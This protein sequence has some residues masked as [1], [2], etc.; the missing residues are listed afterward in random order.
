MKRDFF[1]KKRILATIIIAFAFSIVFS[2]FSDALK[3]EASGTITGSVYVDYNMNGARNTN[4]TAPNYAVDEGVG[5]ATVSLYDS[6]GTLSGTATTCTALNSPT[7][8]CTGNNNGAYSLT[9]TGTGPYR[10]E[11]TNLPAGSNPS[12]IGTNNSTTVR[13]IAD[14]NSS[15]VDL[16][17]VAPAEYCQNVPML[18][19]NSYGVGDVDFDT[20]VRYPYNYSDE[21][22]GRLNSVDSTSWTTAPS[23]T[24]ALNPTSVAGADSI[25]ST[26]GLAWNKY[27]DKLYSAAYLKRGAKFGGL[28]SES[29]GAIYVTSSP[30]AVS[31]STALYVDLNAVFGAGTTGA[32]T[33]PTATTTDW[34]AD[35]A[36]IP[37]IGK[38]GLGGMKISQDGATLYAV[39][40]ADRRLYVIPTSGTLNSTTITRFSVPTS[41]LAVTGGTCATADVRPFAVGRDRSGQIY[42]GAVCSAESETADAKLHAFIWRFSGSAFTLVAN[43]ALSFSRTAGT[44][45]AATWQRWLATVPSSTLN[46]AAPMITDIDFDGDDMILGLRDRYGDQIVLPDYYRGYGDVMRVCA[47]GSNFTFENNGSC[48][49]VTAGGSAL[50]KGPGGGEY[51]SDLNGDSREEGAL[52]GLVQ[53]PGFNHVISTFYDPVSYNSAGTRVNN[54]YTAGIQRYS[55]TTGAMVGAYDVYLEADTGNFGKADGNG[56][57]EV[58]CDKAPIQIGN[59]VWRDTDGDGV[60][61]ANE[62]GIQNV[63]VR[64]YQGST[65]I[66]SAVTD[67]SGN[68]YFSSAAGT[69]TTSAI[70]GLNIQRTTAY[71]IRLDNAAN[72]T[73][74]GAL[75]GLLLT[76]KNQTSQAGFDDGTDS[77]AALIVNPAGSAAGTF[78]VV[79]FTSGSI[80]E[81]NHTFDFGFASSTVYS[82]GNRVWFDTNNDGMINA[83]EVGI[84]NVSVSVFADANADGTPDTPATAVASMNT[85]ANGYYRFD[86]LT[87]GNYV[88]R[89]N[90]TNFTNGASLAGYQNTSGASSADTDSTSVAGQNGENGINPTGAANLIQSNGILSGTINLG[91]PG[92]PTAESDVQA[93]GQGAIDS[94]AN[95]TVDFGFF[96]ACVSGTVWNDNGAGANNNNGILNSG[97]SPISFVKV[98]LYDASNNEVLVGLDGILGTSDDSTVGTWTNSSGNY[99]LCGLAPTQYRVVVTPNGGTSSTPTSNTPDNNIDS[100]DN[101]FPGTAPFVGRITAGLVTVTPGSTGALGNTVVTNANALTSNPTIDFGFVLPPTAIRLDNLAAYTDGNSVSLKWS[102]GGESHNLGFNLYRETNGKRELLNAAPIA[103]SA[104]RS[105][106]ELQASA[107]SYGW[108]DNDA[109]LG[110]VYYLEDI[111]IDGTSTMHGPIS[112]TFK[113]FVNKFERNSVLLNDLN[114]TEKPSAEKESVGERNEEV[115]SFN[116]AQ[117]WQ[118]AAQNAVKIHVNHDGWYQVSA[119]Q[120]QS[121]GFDTNSNRDNWQLFVNAAQVPLKVNLDG[122]IEFFGRGA[123]TLEAGKQVYYLINGS[124]AGLRVSELKAGNVGENPARSFPVT[125][126]RKDRSM[127]VSSLLNGDDSNWFGAIVSTNAQTTQT[128]SVGKFDAEGQAHVSVK[129][130]GL[131]TGAHSVNVRFNE[132]DLGA[133]SL[134]NQE[135]RQ[136]E[137]DVPASSLVEGA[138]SVKLQSIGAGNDISLVDKVSLSYSRKYEPISDKLLFTVAAGQTAK[139]AGF[140][141]GKFV[142][143]QVQDGQVARQIAF[144]TDQ[145]DG[146]YGFGLGAANYDREFIALPNSQPEQAAAVERNFP[147]NWNSAN[148]RADFVII[149]PAILQTQAQ[150]LADIRQNQGL[151]TKVVLAEDVADEFAA[152]GVLTSDAVRQFLQT[153]V[154]TWRVKPKY[155][156]L[157]G[158]SSY[159]SRGYLGQTNRNLIPTR[160]VDTQFMETS[161]DAWLADF[162]D[163]G[164]ENIALGRLPAANEAE[165]NLLIAKLIRY[166]NQSTRAEKSSMMVSDRGF[167]SFTELVQ[168]NLPNDV[169]KVRIDRAAMSDA[170]MRTAILSGLSDNPMVVTYTGHGTT[171]VWSSNSIFNYADAGN[172]NNSQLS[173]YMLMTCLNGFTHNSTGDSLAESALKAENGGAAVVWASSGMT[174]P[175]AQTDMS[176]EATRLIFNQNGNPMRIGDIARLAKQATTDTDVRRTWQIIGDPTIFVK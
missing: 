75:T 52:G 50:N 89:V 67:A 36:T 96:R 143:Y 134:S 146:E 95:M 145:I 69:N 92:E 119:A 61:D 112:P 35:N 70:Y 157:F 138:N 7:A 76:T 150:Q 117:Q 15:N 28:S 175:D 100:D 37:E 43:T 154:T 8:F 82:L 3:T 74:A 17:V 26:F 22:D 59:R 169:R 158:D 80:G 124:S 11:F 21:L 118:I 167:E 55:N 91:A 2:Q 13:F 30:T 62:N 56:D 48:G 162:N 27:A 53:V 122:A 81:N 57:S 99:S 19:T 156:L 168:A 109:K 46:R 140:S 113:V 34:T 77:D 5:G 45:E 176:K 66:S 130:Q 16:G 84:S 78:P 47:N 87:A 101:G 25:G 141:T 107:E 164:I 79:A 116:Q 123:D 51:Y 171:G 174:L 137:F 159:D 88:V 72:Y 127:Y 102:T 110:A 114:G 105:S 136:F 135:N 97:E 64:L 115:S 173:F 23:R 161:S 63:T 71:E 98:R 93:T 144:G 9:A 126:E 142:V 132:I 60:Q 106:V 94:A 103:G 44:S 172:L 18:V 31:P 170:D 39:N 151:L 108:N 111:D 86:N 147:S 58:L 104:L 41:G 29:T 85:D 133:V 153:A 6:S 32:N 12:A 139:V 14:G 120:L 149:A 20:I 1:G 148:N 4:A 165:A 163:D 90:S 129:L 42:V 24:A 73:G 54:Y 49:G 83:G 128:L 155:A 38:R 160:L 68:Y 65:L 40:L 10:V 166:D 152:G 131:T 121:N 33:H 125:V